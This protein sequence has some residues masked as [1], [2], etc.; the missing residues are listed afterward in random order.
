MKIDCP[1]CDEEMSHQVK[2]L[3]GDKEA[4][5]ET[6]CRRCGNERLIPSWEIRQIKS[7]NQA[8]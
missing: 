1:K 6:K 3:G 4:Y 7:I 8:L 5:Y 2:Y